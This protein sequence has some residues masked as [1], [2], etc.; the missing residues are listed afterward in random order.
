MCVRKHVNE[1]RERGRERERESEIG[2]K[3]QRAKERNREREKES[4]KDI[5]SRV[6]QYL[7]NHSKKVLKKFFNL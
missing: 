1:K 5:E 2:K 6:L 7:F 3:R 4:K